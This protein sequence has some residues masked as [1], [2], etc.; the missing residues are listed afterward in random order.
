MPPGLGAIFAGLTYVFS[1]TEVYK[2]GGVAVAAAVGTTVALVARQTLMMRQR[3][4]LSEALAE[5][6]EHFRS[7]VQAS[8]DVITVCDENDVITY[9]S[10]A[11]RGVFGYEPEDILGQRITDLLHLEDLREVNRQ[12]RVLME[13]DDEGAIR[14]DC[15]VRDAR[16]KWLMTESTV[17]DHRASPSIRGLVFNTRDISDRAELEGRVSHLVHHD[18]LTDLPNRTLFRDRLRHLLDARRSR[19]RPATVMV[20]DLDG[21]KAVNEAA[22]HAAGDALLVQCARRLRRFVRGGDTVARL[23]G[24]SF[25]ILLEDDYEV[26]SVVEVA[27]RLLEALAA[28]YAV[29]GRDHV[30]SASIGVA[31]GNPSTGADELLVDAELALRAAKLGGRGRV[32]FFAA[33][34][35]TEAI[36]RVELEAEIRQALTA[37]EFTLD[38]QPV[39]ELSSGQVVGVEALLRW[40]HPRRGWVPPAEVIPV[41]EESGLIVPLGRWILE[42]ACRQVARW[43]RAGYEIDIAVNLSARQLAAPGLV[44]SVA[45]VLR[46]TGVPPSALTLEITENVIVDTEDRTLGKLLLLRELGVRL[47]IDDFGTGYSS[48]SY[49]QRLPVDILKIDRSYISGVGS[50]AELT[51]LTGTIVRL[52]RDLGLTLVA[53][54]IEEPTQLHELVAMGCELGQG[55]PVRR[56]VAGRRVAPHAARAGPDHAAARAHRRQGGRRRARIRRVGAGPASQGLRC[57]VPANLTSRG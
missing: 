34:M 44:D 24:D 39:L 4:R 15:R 41:A 8:S 7:L 18:P 17:T 43:R 48:L 27:H 6:E 11:V 5:R 56:A 52:G 53:E 22:G 26:A 42:E 28:P 36:R 3:I 31:V 51:S 13:G 46:S 45:T 10:P 33:E 38:Y 2:L 21:F 29:A 23:D 50:R 47:A 19:E 37:G 32:E 9:C 35:H 25:A 14:F 16:G 30:I 1:T 49:L 54:G 20:V 55:F 40:N 57:C 12:M